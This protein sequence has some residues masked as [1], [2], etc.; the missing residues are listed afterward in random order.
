MKNRKFR[1]IIERNKAKFSDNS[2]ALLDSRNLLTGKNKV[3]LL[4]LEI[5]KWMKDLLGDVDYKRTRDK[6]EE[7]VED[8]W[9]GND[10]MD[11]NIKL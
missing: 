4:S 7:K 2:S 5:S 3:S 9:V 6:V 8:L 11:L 1:L 10:G